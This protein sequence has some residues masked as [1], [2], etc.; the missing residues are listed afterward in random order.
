MR[1]V[2]SG[3]S[4]NA[5]EVHRWKLQ[6]RE[7]GKKRVGCSALLR[8][9]KS[10]HCHLLHFLQNWALQR[11]GSGRQYLIFRLSFIVQKAFIIRFLFA[12]NLY[13]QTS[14]VQFNGF[15]RC[16]AFTTSLK[17]AF[18]TDLMLQGRPEWSLQTHC[19]LLLS[20]RT[21][22]STCWE[23]LQAVG[24]SEKGHEVQFKLWREERGQPTMDTSVLNRAREYALPSHCTN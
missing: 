7:A 23:R 3:A 20:L 10:P 22:S 1:W 5:E 15:D 21:S 12:Y 11:L 4:V 16:P 18:P 9:Q 8:A 2:F 13:T 6:S 19:N 24:S 14:H 17:M